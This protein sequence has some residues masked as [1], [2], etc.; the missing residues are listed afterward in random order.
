MTVIFFSVRIAVIPIFWYKV[1]SIADSNMWLEMQYLRHVVVATCVVLD[2]INIFWFKKMFMGLIKISSIK[3][4][5]TKR[6][7]L[8]NLSKNN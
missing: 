6:T 5:D 4:K 8:I 1:Y 3:Y 7:T 2:V